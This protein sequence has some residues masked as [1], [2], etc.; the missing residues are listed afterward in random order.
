MNFFIEDLL[1]N[2]L[3][4]ISLVLGLAPLLAGL[5]F[6]F[7]NPKLF[8]L[9]VKNLRRNMLRTGLTCLA[10]MV[11]VFMIT[12]VWT[13][14]FTLDRMTVEKSQDLKLAGVQNVTS[15]ASRQPHP[16]ILTRTIVEHQEPFLVEFGDPVKHP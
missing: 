12:L 6:A 8:L 2:P 14:I 11:L 1:T 10:T 4:Q 15:V 13:V 16:E 3:T 5:I 7:I 9:I